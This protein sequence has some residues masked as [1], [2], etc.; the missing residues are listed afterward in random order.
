MHAQLRATAEQDIEEA[1]AYYRDEGGL[2]TALE[3]VDAL[4]AAI[5]DLCDHPLIG[6][7]RFAFELEIPNLR[8]WSLRRFPYL[9]FYVPDDDRIDIWRVLHARRDIPTFLTADPP[10]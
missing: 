7:L 4:E 1:V 6:T 10:A 8:S 5:V 2:E 9:V 3:F